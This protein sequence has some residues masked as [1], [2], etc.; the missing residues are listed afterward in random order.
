MSAYKTLLFVI[1]LALF[2][3]CAKEPN[4]YLVQEPG[5]FEGRATLEGID[6]NGDG[7]RDDVWNFIA[8][9]YPKPEQ[10]DI[11]QALAQMAK[12]YQNSVIYGALK[13][14]KLAKQYIREEG[15][16]ATACMFIKFPLHCCYRKQKE[17][18]IALETK[19][20]NTDERLYAYWN[21]NALLSGDIYSD[22][23]FEFPCEYDEKRER[24]LNA[25]F[26]AKTLEEINPNLPPD[27]D[28]AGN[29]TLE[30]IDADNDGV[31][32][33]VQR[34]I[35]KF[36]PRPDQERYRAALFQE[37]RSWQEILTVD[38]SDKDAIFRS[39][40][41]SKS[42]TQCIQHSSVRGDY[43]ETELVRNTM[44]NTPRRDEMRDRYYKALD[45]F[46][47]KHYTGSAHAIPCDYD[48][49]KQ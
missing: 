49:A 45:K 36:A 40:D 19:V 23:D 25:A 42:A 31:R 9:S 7:V 3:G 30:G 29:A 32:D 33:D 11:R 4:P 27:P 1:A 34:T 26:G 14:A 15:G 13:N 37:A 28:R 46:K 8:K 41:N 38:L 5:Y 18:F 44:L 22:K 17:M 16:R 12:V 35:W 47:I 6:S 24:E 48:K 10:E 20:A 39:R 2:T 21:F 43:R